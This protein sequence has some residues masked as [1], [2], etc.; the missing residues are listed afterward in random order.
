MNKI[1]PNGSLCLFKKYTGGSRNGL[2][3]LV[4]GSEIQDADSGANYTI[5]EYSSKK[6][7][8]EEGW[9]HEEIILK[10]LSTEP[11]EPI[12]LR[13]EETINFQVIGIFVRVLGE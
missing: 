2:I 10:P 5:K 13:D 11:Y 8:D 12:V 6:S 9:H 4:E 3:V 7:T 1:I